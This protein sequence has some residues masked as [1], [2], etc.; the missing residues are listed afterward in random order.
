MI[1]SDVEQST[2]KNKHTHACITASNRSGE[3]VRVPSELSGPK[4]MPPFIYL[5]EV[6]VTLASM[7]KKSRHI[8][9][10]VDPS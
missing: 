2:W 3:Q 9:H 6:K 5:D 7:A 10:Q 8:V 1:V 4:G